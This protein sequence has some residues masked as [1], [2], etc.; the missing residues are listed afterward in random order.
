LQESIAPIYGKDDTFIV[1]MLPRYFQY[2]TYAREIFSHGV[3]GA[4]AKH[5]KVTNSKH[6]NGEEVKAEQQE[7][8]A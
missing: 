6:Q 2:F 8:V 4:V 3:T 7:G 1:V 5:D